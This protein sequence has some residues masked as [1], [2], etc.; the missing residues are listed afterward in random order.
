ML[1]QILYIVSSILIAIALIGLVIVFF[2]MAASMAKQ[3]REAHAVVQQRPVYHVKFKGRSRHE[4]NAITTRLLQEDKHRPR[5]RHA[6]V[7]VVR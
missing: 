3:D 7:I 6:Q 5:R 1:I 4:L 2:V